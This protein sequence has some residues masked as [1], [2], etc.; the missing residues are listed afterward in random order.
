M[1]PSYRIRIL[2][3]QIGHRQLA[4]VDLACL[5]GEEGRPPAPRTGGSRGQRRRD[6]VCNRHEAPHVRPRPRRSLKLEVG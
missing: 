4:A 1:I 6:S 5:G 3:L 2:V